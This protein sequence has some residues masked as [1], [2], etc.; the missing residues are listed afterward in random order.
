MSAIL[1]IYL[2]IFYI[3]IFFFLLLSFF[4]I[5]L[6]LFLYIFTNLYPSVCLC[7]YLVAP[8]IT[9]YIHN[10]LQCM[11]IIILHV[12]VQKLFVYIFTLPHL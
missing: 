1:F 5:I 3:S 9:A 4:L 2:F 10:L 12:R 7:F 6:F 11:G 8:H